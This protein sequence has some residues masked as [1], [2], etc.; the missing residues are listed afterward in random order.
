MHDECIRSSLL[1]GFRGGRD[2]RFESIVYAIS[3]EIQRR[4]RLV[5]RWVDTIVVPSGT[6]ADVLVRGGY[7]ARRIQIVPYGVP[8]TDVEPS[9]PEFALYAGRLSEEKGLRTLL[10]AAQQSHVPLAIAGSGPLTEIVRKHSGNGIRFLGSLTQ[11]ELASARARAA[12][13]VVPS[14]WRDVLP[15]A[16]LE[17]L[18]QG[19]PVIASEIGRNGGVQLVPA[20]DEAALA[21]AMANLW[22]DSATRAALAREARAAAETKYS[23]VGQTQAL[24]DI[25]EG[26]AA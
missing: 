4:L 9:S 1:C 21:Y 7:D 26:A 19:I 6:V 14:E 22:E 17:A 13:V 11:Q 15:F 24:V 8:L 2:S 23:F 5:E 12:F 3:I 16:A 25:Y 20:G 10:R 18:A